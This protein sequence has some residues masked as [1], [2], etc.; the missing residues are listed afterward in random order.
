MAKGT[1]PSGQTTSGH[2]APLLSSSLDCCVF[3]TESN[4]VSLWEPNANHLP[5]GPPSLFTK[6]ICLNFS[7]KHGICISMS[8]YTL[9]CKD[10]LLVSNEN[11]KDFE[12]PPQTEESLN[13]RY[14]I[15]RLILIGM[16]NAYHFS[17]L[18]HSTYCVSSLPTIF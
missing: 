12:L 5:V 8:N 2:A 6:L 17:S 18:P 15:Y 9:V 4:L 7:G 16:P 3:V 11:R 13:N 14:S 1:N 10:D